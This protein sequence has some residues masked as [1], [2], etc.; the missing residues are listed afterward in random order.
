[1]ALFYL[2]WDFPK[3]VFN[4]VIRLGFYWVFIRTKKELVPKFPFPWFSEVNW[5]V[6]KEKEPLIRG[7]RGN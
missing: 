1:V 4:G 2:S 7:R 3:K 5:K 6:I